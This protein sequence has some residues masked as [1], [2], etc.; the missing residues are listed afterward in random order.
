MDLGHCELAFRVCVGKGP[1]LLLVHGYP[2]SSL[3]FRRVAASLANSGF[4]CYMP[5]LPGLGETKYTAATDFKFAAQA[6]TLKK[7]VDTLGI[8]S[9]SI[10]AHDTG[11][12]I[13]R[14]TSAH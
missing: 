4:T 11:A 8:Q 6:E 13:S 10:L 9:Y 14:Q 1:A 2:L 5:D 12:T 3:T 7:F